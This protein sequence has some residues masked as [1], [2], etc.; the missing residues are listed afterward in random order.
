MQISNFTSVNPTMG[1]TRTYEN[2]SKWLGDRPARLGVVSRLYE[3]LT[4]SYLTESLRNIFYRDKKS[5]DKYRSLDSMYFDWEVETNNIKRIEFAAVPTE[6][7]ANGTEITMAFKENYYQKNDIFS[8]DGSTQQCFVVSRPVRKNDHYWEVNVRLIDN[9]YSS[10]LDPRACQIGMT[11]RW[12]GNAQPELHKEG[13][14]KYQSNVAKQRNYITT[15]RVDDSWSARYAASEDLFIKIGKGDGNGQLKEVVYRMDKKE[16]VLLD[17]FMYVRNNMLLFA[18]C[19]VNPKTNKPTI[20]DPET[21]EPIY[22]GDGIIPQVERYASKYAFSKLTSG[23]FQT[24]ISTMAEKAEKPTGNTFMFIINERMWQLVQVA[25][26]D[27]LNHNHTDGAFLWSQ[28]A[29]DYVKVGATYNAYEWAGNT[30]IFQVDRTFSR[31]YGYEKGYALCLDLTA[32]STG[33]EPPIAMFTLKGGDFITNTVLG[34]GGKDGLS[35]GVVSTPVA[36]SKMINWGLTL[37]AA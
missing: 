31:E 35:S 3:D 28:K 18:K 26:S 24:V 32:H 16:K 6:D 20:Y 9:D 30:I 19:N 13:Y 23:V 12:I 29:N 11:T 22:I 34:V 10:I 8:I 37:Q 5:S 36:G 33:A 4:A 7:G 17:N 2:F 21:N 14:V 1:E 15:H 27:W 25:L